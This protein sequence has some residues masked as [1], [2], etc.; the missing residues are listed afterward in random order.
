[1]GRITTALDPPQFENPASI[2][3]NG[4]TAD[5]GANPYP[6]TIT[7]SGLGG[8]I[9]DV[10]LRLTGLSHTFPDDV[11]ILLSSP[12]GETLRVM[13]DNGGGG[14]SPADT[15]GA[16]VER[17]DLQRHERRGRKHPR[18]RAAGLRQVP[19]G[20]RNRVEHVARA[21]AGRSVHQ[22]PP[23]L[24]CVRRGPRQRHLEA[25]GQRR[26]RRG[27]RKD[28]RRLGS[29]HRHA[30][31]REPRHDPR[32]ED[33]SPSLRNVLANDTGSPL[34]DREPS[35]TPRTGRRPSIDGSPDDRSTTGPTRTTATAPVGD[36]DVFTY[37]LIER[38]GTATVSAQP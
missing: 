34:D 33:S 38:L 8:A 27:H 1:M 30:W 19:A 14:L 20:V 7:V 29:R 25:L 17:R 31:A 10:R 32:A 28:L 23:V 12:S 21:R 11:D 13:S 4:L 37:E 2:D 16:A 24:L 6:S 9:T 36:P 22:L 5:L 35:P 18:P 15:I 26:R 3:I